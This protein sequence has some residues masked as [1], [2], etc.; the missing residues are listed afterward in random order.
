MK[1]TFSLM[2]LCLLAT[3]T[4]LAQTVITGT[5][6]SAHD[7]EPVIGATVKVKGASLGAVTDVNGKFSIQVAA[8][9]TLVVS[10]GH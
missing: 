5:V 9:K 4:T 1:R 2:L 7:N 10:W 6:V 8:G 3:L